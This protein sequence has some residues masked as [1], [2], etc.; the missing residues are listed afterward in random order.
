MRKL[1]RPDLTEIK[2]QMPS[3]KAYRPRKPAL[4]SSVNDEGR[5][6]LVGA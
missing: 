2:E 6:A 3:A 1:I 4:V 5:D